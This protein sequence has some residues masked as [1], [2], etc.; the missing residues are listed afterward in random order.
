[1]FIKNLKLID[2]KS[3]K[4]SLEIGPFHPYLNGIIGPNG[5]G[6]SNILDAILFVFGEKAISM[7]SKKLMQ[8][9]CSTNERTSLFASSSIFLFLVKNKSINFFK[10]IK[11]LS[12]SRKIFKN[13]NSEYFINGKKIKLFYLKQLLFFVNIP[14]TTGIFS[15]KQ[16]EIEQYS[17]MESVGK[18]KK[19]TGLIE[20][21]EDIA[22]SSCYFW[23]MFKKFNTIFNLQFRKEIFYHIT[24]EKIKQDNFFSN[25]NSSEHSKDEFNKIFFI[26][27]IILNLNNA[28]ISKILKIRKAT[29]SNKIN[30]ILMEKIKKVAILN[31]CTLSYVN[32]ILEKNAC[33]SSQTNK[34]NSWKIFYKIQEKTIF[35]GQKRYNNLENL[36]FLK[37]KIKKRP[38]ALLYTLVNF[39]LINRSEQNCSFEVYMKTMKSKII[40]IKNKKLAKLY[41]K[42]LTIIIPFFDNFI[43]NRIFKKFLELRVVALKKNQLILKNTKKISILEQNILSE[44]FCNY[45]FSS[46]VSNSLV[47]KINCL[48]KKKERILSLIKK[49]KN[50]LNYKK[51]QEFLISKKKFGPFGLFLDLMCFL[52][53][54]LLITFGTIFLNNPR[55]LHQEN[56]IFTLYEAAYFRKNFNKRF[57]LTVG[58][59]VYSFKELQALS[60]YT[61]HKFLT[62]EEN[63]LTIKKKALKN[64]SRKANL[65]ECLEKMRNSIITK[66]CY[67][68]VCFE[69]GKTILNING[70]SVKET[71]TKNLMLL[72]TEKNNNKKTKNCFINFFEETLFKINRRK[73]K[74]EYDFIKTKINAKLIELKSKSFNLKLNSLKS[75]EKKIKLNGD[76]FF[77]PYV[78]SFHQLLSELDIID[79]SEKFRSRAF[80]LERFRVTLSTIFQLLIFSIIWGSSL[81]T[82]ASSTNKQINLLTYYDSDIIRNKIWS[83]FLKV[84]VLERNLKKKKDKTSKKFT[85]LSKKVIKNLKYALVCL[86]SSILLKLSL[87]YFFLSVLSE[88][89]ANIKNRIII[90]GKKKL[91][92][93]CFWLVLIKRLT[94][95]KKYILKM[96][97]TSTKLDC[98]LN[99]KRTKCKKVGSVE[100]ESQRYFHSF[101]IKSNSTHRTYF[102]KNFNFY[103]PKKKY[104]SRFISVKVGFFRLFKKLYLNKN[105]GQLLKKACIIRSDVEMGKYYCLIKQMDCHVCTK[106]INKL[107]KNEYSKITKDY[108]LEISTVNKN[109]MFLMGLQLKTYHEKKKG[110]SLFQMSG[111]EKTLSSLCLILSSQTLLSSKWVIFDEIDAALDFKNIANISFQLQSKQKKWQ[112]LLITLRNNMLSYINHIFGIYRIK[113]KTKTIC[114][115]I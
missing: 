112:I 37:Q 35:G 47:I 39:F 36:N 19:K 49:I 80:Q 106:M 107:N 113:T 10:K 110:Q 115:R 86:S 64:Y 58:N 22:R 81:K 9:I 66:P 20:F 85:R 108:R 79:F 54:S 32:F 3:Y 8:L 1:M 43:K 31:N 104:Q 97:Q 15:I 78:K 76:F 89:G 114:L 75:K 44:K 111:G 90:L 83:N 87:S 70:I 38:P 84:L 2:F 109:D 56:G 34:K 5:I 33:I 100:I 46:L 23:V 26:N 95:Y 18:K 24:Y 57:S 98:M 6:K 63:F 27:V 25:K 12:L 28:I 55:L 65:N 41:Q 42:F 21:I 52:H 11:E 68:K 101:C 69:N 67:G 88:L 60:D 50:E 7:R 61:N 102:F 74:K 30:T 92:L 99:V 45:S 4:D 59:Q 17:R 94:Y 103:Y 29:L 72:L 105:V 16:G 14:F 51:N 91:E 48:A 77:G 73:N 93:D 96:Y 62:G 53:I 82:H 71:I 40:S 13:G